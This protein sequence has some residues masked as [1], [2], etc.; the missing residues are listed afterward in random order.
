MRKPCDAFTAFTAINVDIN[1]II[2]CLPPSHRGKSSAVFSPGLR[3]C[4]GPRRERAGCCLGT[5]IST[6]EP[7]AGAGA[8]GI[9]CLPVVPRTRPST[10]SIFSACSHDRG[11]WPQHTKHPPFRF[12]F[13]TDS[14]KRD[15]LPS[16]GPLPS[17]VEGPGA[18][19]QG[20]S[21]R[22]KKCPGFKGSSHKN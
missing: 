17:S 15:L 4:G 19:G 5:G 11:L 20:W 2:C 9:R 13:R 1:L 6:T 16:Q 12:S 21:W 3:P 10:T 8:R 18:R 22:Q 7:P 14:G